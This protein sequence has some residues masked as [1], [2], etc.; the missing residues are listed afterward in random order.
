MFLVSSPT[1]KD[2]VLNAVTSGRRKQGSKGARRFTRS[3]DIYFLMLLST[4][5]QGDRE[6]YS[7]ALTDNIK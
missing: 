4:H 5:T 1:G 3:R 6:T 2:P 7:C